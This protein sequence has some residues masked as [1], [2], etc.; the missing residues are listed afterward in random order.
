[1]FWPLLEFSLVFV[2]SHLYYDVSNVINATCFPFF[3][4]FFGVYWASGIFGLISFIGSEKFWPLSHQIL[5]LFHSLT[6]LLWD[7]TYIL[8]LFLCSH[9]SFMLFSVFSVFF[10]V[11]FS[12]DVFHEICPFYY[13]LKNMSNLLSISYI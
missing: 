7:F 3:W 10:C 13:L 8:T 2:F 1:M 12:K 11:C 4:I 9:S 5:L 6:L